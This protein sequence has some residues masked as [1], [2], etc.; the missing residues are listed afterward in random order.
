MSESPPKPAA[1]PLNPIVAQ[2]RARVEARQRRERLP[3]LIGAGVGA[4]LL[5]LALLLGGAA[6]Q[7][8]RIAGAQVS[9]EALSI[10]KESEAAQHLLGLPLRTEGVWSGPLLLWEPKGPLSGTVRVAGDRGD[11]ELRFTGGPSDGMTAFTQ[12]ELVELHSGQDPALRRLDL[13][14][15]AE[16]RARTHREG[17]VAP[18]LAEAER[19]AKR[20]DLQAAERMTD[21]VLVTEPRHLEALSLRA[22]LRHERDD[23]EGAEDDLLF[24]LGQDPNRAPDQHRLGRVRTARGDHQGCV[25]AFTVL[26]RDNAGDAA[27]W[28]GRAGCQA[29]QAAEPPDEAL[30]RTAAAGAR[31]ACRL[32]EAE[33]CALA[34]QLAP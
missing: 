1:E 34:K 4:L 10:A 6:L 23:F 21:R 7:Q 19:L 2:A 9:Q 18:D 32:G 5:G 31:E 27:A 8:A 14:P 26:I 33:G 3:V 29:A 13:L 25:K 24:V 12:L 16:E 30:R 22:R 17:L 28:F 20:G 15:A 11:A